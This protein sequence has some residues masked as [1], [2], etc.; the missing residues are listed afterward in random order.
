MPTEAGIQSVVD[1]N[2]FKD[3]DSRSRLKTCRDRFRG[4]DG[5]LAI[6]AQ[7]LLAEEEKGEGGEF[8]FGSAFHYLWEYQ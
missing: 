4:N 6:A 1:I 3:L 7:S 2:N 5:A 8:R